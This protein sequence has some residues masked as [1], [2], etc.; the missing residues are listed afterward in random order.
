MTYCFTEE[1]YRE[2]FPRLIKASKENIIFDLRTYMDS[3]PLTDAVW[4]T[5]SAI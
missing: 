2:G 3:H 5:V 1:L 4:K